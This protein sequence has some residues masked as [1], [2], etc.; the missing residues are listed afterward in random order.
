MFKVAVRV[1]GKTLSQAG[2]LW[3]VGIT[4]PYVSNNSP[5]VRGHVYV[6]NTLHEYITFVKLRPR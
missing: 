1:L 5:Q 6:L 3:N 2:R 4:A